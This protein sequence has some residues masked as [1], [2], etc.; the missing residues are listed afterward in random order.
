[1]A[2]NSFLETM[3]LID[4]I[5][6]IALGVSFVVGLT[7]GLIRQAFSLG[8]LIVGIICGAMLYRPGA[9]FLTGKL[10]MEEHTAQV[11]AFIVILLLVPI[12]FGILGRLLSKLVHAA[13]LGFADRV[14]G[15]VF[16]VLKC[17]VIMG[18]AFQLMEMTGLSE[19]NIVNGGSRG[20]SR[21]YEPVRKASDTCLKW[22]WNKV[23]EGKEKLDLPQLSDD[24]KN[25]I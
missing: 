20:E 8:G 21:F 2:L 5:I 16:G 24:G 25:N 15:A 14:L 18:L 6:L 4:Y 22:A 11:V 9:T 19:K 23:L 17:F 7:K 13:S 3:A 1:M 12:A 10:G